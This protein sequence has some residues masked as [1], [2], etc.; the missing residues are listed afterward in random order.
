[1]HTLEIVGEAEDGHG[2]LR[3]WNGRLMS[4]ITE[5]GPHSLEEEASWR[6][7]GAEGEGRGGG[8]GGGGGQREW[9]T[10]A[11]LAPRNSAAATGASSAMVCR[12]YPYVRKRPKSA[13]YL[14]RVRE[15]SA[16][17]S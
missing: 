13:V 6:R 1:M 3:S 4:R 2:R 15:L 10:H 14:P 5:Q 8:G 7:D 12:L 17:S 16:S 11:S 9:A